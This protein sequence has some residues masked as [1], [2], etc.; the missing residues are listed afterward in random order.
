MCTIVDIPA[1]VCGETN[2]PGIARILAIPTADLDTEV[3]ATTGVVASFDIA[4]G[5]KFFEIFFSDTSG[6]MLATFNGET[7]DSE[8]WTAGFNAFVSKITGARNNAIE[9]YVGVPLV[10]VGVDSNGTKQV[11]GSKLHPVYMTRAEGGTGLKEEGARNGYA[12]TFTLRLSNHANY[13]YS[14]DI[15]TITTEAA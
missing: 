14:G 10:M 7:P 12:M 5:K 9:Q 6:E 4:T 13:E 3:T 8:F 2:T 15:A 1:K 11:V